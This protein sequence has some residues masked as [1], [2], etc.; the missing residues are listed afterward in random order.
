MVD[1]VITATSVTADINNGTVTRPAGATIAAGQMVYLVAA[2]GKW[3]LADADSATAAAR[4]PDGIALNGG[5]ANQP[6]MVKTKGEVTMNAVLSAGVAYYLSDAA[7]A[8]CPV[9][10]LASGDYPCIVGIARSTTVLTLG[11][12]ASPVAL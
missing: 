6:I 10:D 5:A 8:V 3:A 4:V 12:Q 7:G 2:T 11:I 9:A 1:L